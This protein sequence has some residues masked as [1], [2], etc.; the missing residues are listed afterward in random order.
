MRVTQN[1]TANLVLQSLQSIVQRQTQLEQYASTGSKISLPSDDPVA[2]QQILKLKAQN[3]AQNQY[4]RNISNATALLTMSDSAMSAMSDVLIRA[5]EL[6]LATSN[7]TNSDESMAAAQKEM[8][9]LKSQMITLGN[10]QLNGK[11]IFGGYRNDVPPFDTTTGAFQ[12]ATIDATQL[13]ISQGTLMTV[14]YSGATLVSGGIPAGS[15][16]VDIMKSFDNMIAA[17]NPPSS[18]AG[19]QAELGNLDKAASQVLVGRSIMGANL[20]RL[21]NLSEVA[22]DKKIATDKVLSNLQDVDFTQVMSD[23]SKQQIAYSAAVAAS[24]KISQISLLDYLK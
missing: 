3:T 11:Y 16:G 23:L 12:P 13:E 6:A 10:S 24:A 5:K 4:D 1:T 8:Q 7:G 14:D 2:T 18:S 9:Q 19:V 22:A 15:T 20:N 17:M 21:T